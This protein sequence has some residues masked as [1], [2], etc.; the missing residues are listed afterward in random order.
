MILV[1][2][3]SALVNHWCDECHIALHVY[4]NTGLYGR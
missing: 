3:L 2:M 1:E 4:I